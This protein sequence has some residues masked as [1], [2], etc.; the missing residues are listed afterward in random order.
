MAR[1][2]RE[3][4]GAWRRFQRHEF[5]TP[6]PDLARYVERYW[7]VSWHYREPYRQLVVP[8]PYVHLTFHDGQATVQGVSSGYG[9]KVLEGSS[10]VF[11]VAFRP[12]C[13]R[14]F[15]GRSVSTIT[16]RS[17]DATEVFGPDLP[18]SLEVP[19]VEQFLRAHLPEPDPRTD[20][21]ADIVMKIAAKPEI[22]RVDE[23]ASTLDTSVR[24]L[25][26]LFAD[27]VGIGPK[28][29]IRRY[30]LREVTERLAQGVEIDWASLAAELGYADQAHFVRD[31]TK[32]FGE[33]PTQYAER[34]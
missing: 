27:Y 32:M 8:Y 21:V 4:G 26:R 23:L 9:I 10:G 5:P 11:G 30:R 20:E 18:D 12:G 1:D 28:W 17:F 15:L 31:F 16:D 33:P 25:Q 3:L 2:T 22:T 7:V 14:P 34:Y 13:F 24:Q 19:A 29:V 6:S